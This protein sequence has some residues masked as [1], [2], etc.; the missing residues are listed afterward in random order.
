MIRN[1]GSWV[2]KARVPMIKGVRTVLNLGGAVELKSRRVLGIRDLFT[3]RYAPFRRVQCGHRA[4]PDRT[5]IYSLRGLNLELAMGHG[6]LSNID[7]DH[8]YFISSSLVIDIKISRLNISEIIFSNRRSVHPSFQNSDFSIIVSLPPN[9]NLE[10]PL[11]LSPRGI[12]WSTQKT[13]TL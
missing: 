7:I 8:G 10:G 3:A 11:R 9:T 12:F 5:G 13:R 1:S 6:T 4:D 2:W